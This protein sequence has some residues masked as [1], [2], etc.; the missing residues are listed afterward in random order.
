MEDELSWAQTRGRRESG[1]GRDLGGGGGGRGGRSVL[2]GL[3]LI[4]LGEDLAGCLNE[5]L[6]FCSARNVGLLHFEE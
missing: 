6:C 4:C 3:A 2:L 1:R 5:L